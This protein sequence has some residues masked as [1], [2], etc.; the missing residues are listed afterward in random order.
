MQQR[1]HHRR[2][3]NLIVESFLQWDCRSFW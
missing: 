1:S 3:G 2:D